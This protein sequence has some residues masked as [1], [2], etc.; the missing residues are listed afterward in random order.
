MDGLSQLDELLR[1]LGVSLDDVE[2]LRLLP[3]EEAVKH[4]EALK[5]KVRRGWKRAVFDLHP[6]RTGGDPEKTARFHELTRARDAFEAFRLPVPDVRGAVVEYRA[7][8]VPY[9]PGVIF[10]PQPRK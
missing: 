2:S 10:Y 3:Y 1:T 7:D 4:L 6:D 8:Q 9:T 5:D